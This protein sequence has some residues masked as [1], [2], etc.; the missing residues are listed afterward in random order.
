MKHIWLT[1]LLP[2][3]SFAMDCAVDGISDSPQLM[4]CYIHSSMLIKDLTLECR[5]GYYQIGWGNK[6]HQVEEAYHE[7]VESGSNPLVFQAGRLTLKTTSYKI[8][9]RADVVVDGEK[10]TASA[11]IKLKLIR[12]IFTSE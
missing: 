5:D 11:S 1:L 6:M 4:S 7:E 2:V 9:S 12:R 10:M 3:S 8:Y